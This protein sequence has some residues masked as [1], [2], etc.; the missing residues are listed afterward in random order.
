MDAQG[1]YH[2]SVYVSR[3]SVA[4]GGVVWRFHQALITECMRAIPRTSNSTSLSPIRA[5]FH[6]GLLVA[7]WVGACPCESRQAPVVLTLGISL[8]YC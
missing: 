6:D 1:C 5:S 7:R 3:R 2:W 8:W 4:A